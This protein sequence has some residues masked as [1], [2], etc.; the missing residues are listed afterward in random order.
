MGGMMAP[1]MG[2]GAGGGGSQEHENKSRVVANPEDLFGSVED[3]SP[4]VIG[5]EEA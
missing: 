4:S 5:E 3:A 1:M 2:A